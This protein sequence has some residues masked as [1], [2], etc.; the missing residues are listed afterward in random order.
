M[1]SRPVGKRK[2]TTESSPYY[3]SITVNKTSAIAENKEK[4]PNNLVSLLAGF[5]KDINQQEDECTD[6]D[7]I[8]KTE[9]SMDD[10]TKV[11]SC[12]DPPMS[13]PDIVMEQQHLALF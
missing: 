6:F 3:S 5:E 4:D 7:S 8:N 2:R 12:D 13:V 11:Y 9:T 1:F 10:D